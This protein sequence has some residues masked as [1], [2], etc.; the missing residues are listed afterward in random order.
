MTAAPPPSGPARELLVFAPE[1]A[2]VAAPPGV[3]VEVLPASLTP[4]QAVASARAPFVAFVA[5]G[6]RPDLPRLAALAGV[7]AA[8]P[9]PVLAFGRAEPRAA[10]ADPALH[11]WAFPMSEGPGVVDG[12]L[13]AA[14]VLHHGANVLGPPAVVVVRA[15]AVEPADGLRG[16]VQEP[17][18]HLALWLTLLARG[19][20]WYDPAPAAA[21]DG[22]ADDVPAWDAVV[23]LAV[24]MGLLPPEEAVGALVARLARVGL[25][26]QR[27]MEVAGGLSGSLPAGLRGLATGLDAA[28][29]VPR[30]EID[31]LVL[32]D[33]DHVA[34]RASARAAAWA[35][36]VVVADRSGAA[37]PRE[38]R[39]GADW[40]ATD[41][42]GA[43]SAG[44]LT[45]G[46]RP[47]LVVAAGELP[48]VLDAGQ[49]ATVGRTAGDGFAAE[50]A[51]NASC[52][53]RLVSPGPG[54]DARVGGA[55]VVR[56]HSVHLASPDERDWLPVRLPEA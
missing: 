25:A 6:D 13:L 9:V 47:V 21:T 32:A 55:S 27:K 7:L 33:G 52:E 43:G 24:G 10:A 26:A 38:D 56:V 35:R 8:D 46:D 23:R 15:S 29:V 39:A 42:Q 19:P 30:P 17:G 50:V 16:T 53:V 18:T 40:V 34:A 22:D 12:R 51:G 49:L 11:P 37:L 45:T 36:R 28:A 4:A 14:G 3:R 44:L 41:W 2:T 1:P 54:A 5:P 31:V 20:A 48:E